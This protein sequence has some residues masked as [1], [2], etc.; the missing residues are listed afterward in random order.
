MAGGGLIAICASM[1][2]GP[3]TG[4]TARGLVAKAAVVFII[5]RKSHLYCRPELAG[6]SLP[7]PARTAWTVPAR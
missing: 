1:V 7:G 3:V 6:S 2:P 5:S 4:E